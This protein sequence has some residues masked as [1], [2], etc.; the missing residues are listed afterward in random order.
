ISIALSPRN[1]ESRSRHHL[2][3]AGDV[4]EAG[5]PAWQP[6]VHVR[7]LAKKRSYWRPPDGRGAGAA[8]RLLRAFGKNEGSPASPKRQARASGCRSAGFRPALAWRFGLAGLDVIRPAF[9]PN[10]LSR[11][12]TTT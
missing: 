4:T 6:G 9:F 3:N 7:F 11:V 12:V 1:S 5:D 10:A 2:A 8:G